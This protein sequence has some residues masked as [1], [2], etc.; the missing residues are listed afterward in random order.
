MFT[1]L[2]APA[3]ALLVALAFTPA[4]LA[5]TREERLAVATEYNDAAL[6]DMDMDAMITTMWEPLVTQV[7]PQATDEQK[8]QIHA[9]YVE[10]FQPRMTEMMKQQPDIMADIYSLEELEALRDFYA[11]PVGKS[12]IMKLPQVMQAI[13][14]QLMAMVQETIP[15]I[16]PQVQQILEPQ[17]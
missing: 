8:D 16:I 2:K 9:L 11:T 13:Q 14:P 4:A 3:Y 15:T 5:E 10:T 12:V 6:A 17:Q 1:M 7:A